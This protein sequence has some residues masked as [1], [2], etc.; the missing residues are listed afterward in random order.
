MGARIRLFDRSSMSFR[1]SR[2]PKAGSCARRAD[3]KNSD[4]AHFARLPPL[5][6]ALLIAKLSNG[7]IR[8]ER[9]TYPTMERDDQ[10]PRSEESSLR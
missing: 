6:P 1:R 9:C 8:E 7:H 3:P 10:H 5:R 4:R 2:N